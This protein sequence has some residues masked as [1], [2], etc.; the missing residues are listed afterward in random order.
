MI[1]FFLKPN[2]THH[3]SSHH[4]ITSSLLTSIRFICSH[5]KP[6]RGFPNLIQLFPPAFFFHFFIDIIFRQSARLNCAT[7]SQQRHIAAPILFSSFF[8]FSFFRSPP[9]LLAQRFPRLSLSNTK[10]PLASRRLTPS[11][12]APLLVPSLLINVALNVKIIVASLFSCVL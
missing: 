11:R 7:H 1:I 5:P 9:A 4:Q 10:S 6:L 2:Q 3:H 8:W 12:A